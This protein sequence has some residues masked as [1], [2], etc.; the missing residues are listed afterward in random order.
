MTTEEINKD[1][2]I[3]NCEKCPWFMDIAGRPECM[4]S[5]ETRKDRIGCYKNPPTIGT[6]IEQGKIPTHEEI[7]RII[8][9]TSFYT[10]L[11]GVGE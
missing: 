2:G 1:I 10:D 3:T 6:L 11:P 4:A 5:E 9:S 7:L 8:G